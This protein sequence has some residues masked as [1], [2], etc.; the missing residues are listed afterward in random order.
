[1]DTDSQTVKISSE[2]VQVFHVFMLFLLEK[3]FPNC[4]NFNF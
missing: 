1:M 4:Q 2:K 3:C